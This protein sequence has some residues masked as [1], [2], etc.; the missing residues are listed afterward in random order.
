MVDEHNYCLAP[1]LFFLEHSS[2]LL[3]F[4][5]FSFF[6]S[7]LF[8]SSSQLA[9]AFQGLIFSKRQV[10]IAW[11]CTK[12]QWELSTPPNEKKKSLFTFSL[13]YPLHTQNMMKK[14]FLLIVYVCTDGWIDGYPDLFFY[15]RLAQLSLHPTLGNQSC[16]S[17][18]GHGYHR[19]GFKTLK[20]ECASHGRNI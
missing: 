17:P 4:S 10:V 5:F 12:P 13:F 14:N 19:T 8:S 16:P 15:H 11:A 6:S 7:P 9:T 3:F 1:N 18:P 20:K 2:W